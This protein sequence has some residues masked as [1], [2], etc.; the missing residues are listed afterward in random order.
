LALDPLSKPHVVAVNQAEAQ[1][2][3][4]SEGVRIDWSDK[5]LGFE[6]GGEALWPSPC[7]WGMHGHEALR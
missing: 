2:W 1:F 3:Q 7:H 5:I 4:R 6:C